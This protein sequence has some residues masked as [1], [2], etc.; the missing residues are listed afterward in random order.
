MS[1]KEV[2]DSF[3]KIYIYIYKKKIAS[4]QAA[5]FCKSWDFQRDTGN[6]CPTSSD[7]YEKLIYFP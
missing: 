4:R 1:M 5:S 6:W 7:S 3:M 2:K